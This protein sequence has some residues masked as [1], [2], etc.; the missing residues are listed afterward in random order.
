MLLLV[1][2]DQL[3]FVDFLPECVVAELGED[4]LAVVEVG[5]EAALLFAEVGAQ[6]VRVFT[7]EQQFL[8][9]LQA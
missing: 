9:V 1:G 3:G 7:S 4:Q 6:A 5:E 8:C 2:D